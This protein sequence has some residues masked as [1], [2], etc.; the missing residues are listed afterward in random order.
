MHA[1]LSA[2]RFVFFFFFFFFSLSLSLFPLDLHIPVQASRLSVCL[3]KKEEKKNT[4][5]SSFSLLISRLA[6]RR[7]NTKALSAALI[8]QPGRLLT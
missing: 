2:L 8:L 3:K 4:Y 1:Y 7:S 6:P 5:S